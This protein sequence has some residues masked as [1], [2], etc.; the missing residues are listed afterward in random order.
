M[1]N[2]GFFSRDKLLYLLSQKIKIFITYYY[3]PFD[4]NVVE[5]ESD[6][7]SWSYIEFT[8]EEQNQ[9][10]VDNVVAVGKCFIDKETFHVHF[11]STDYERNFKVSFVFASWN[12]F[13]EYTLCSYP[14]ELLSRFPVEDCLIRMTISQEDEETTHIRIE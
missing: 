3:L 13:V 11:Q 1:E 8:T 4:D 14:T 2:G 5:L 6:G 9:K 10:H 7:L 12:D